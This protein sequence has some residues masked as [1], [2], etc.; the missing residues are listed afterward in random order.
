LGH[1]ITK[2][3]DNHLT[4]KIMMEAETQQIFKTDPG[5][6]LRLIIFL[7]EVADLIP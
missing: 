6:I 5:F 1:T 7:H 2:G 4:L 3:L